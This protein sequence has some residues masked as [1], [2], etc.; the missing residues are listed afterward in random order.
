MSRDIFI[1]SWGAWFTAAPAA[2]L[3]APDG[4][5]VEAQACLRVDDL[6]SEPR[7]RLQ[8]L[9]SVARRS[10]SCRARRPA[11]KCRSA[12]ISAL[13]LDDLLT[14]AQRLGRH[15]PV[16]LRTTR[17]SQNNMNIVATNAGASGNGFLLGG[18][19][20]GLSISGPHLDRWRRCHGVS[21]GD[22]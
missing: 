17:C 18:T 20:T 7:H 19:V 21:S 10:R 13:T 22:A 14:F 3:L 11:I 2:T 12:A 9:N 8:H 6:Q 5:P 15:Q 1:D 16:A 4:P